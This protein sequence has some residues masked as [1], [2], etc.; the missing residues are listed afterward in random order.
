MNGKRIWSLGGFLVIAMIVMGTP[1][2]ANTEADLKARLDRAEAR[3]AELA[4]SQNMESRTWLSTQ[5]AEEVKELVREVL[6]DADMRASLLEGSSAGHNGDHFFL[7][8]DDGSFLL[9]VGGQIQIRHND[10]T[11][12]LSITKQ[13]KLILTK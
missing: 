2:L 6:A 12:R 13:G 7:S 3:I 9:M 8:N 5:R 10:E 1:A 11:Y 4:A